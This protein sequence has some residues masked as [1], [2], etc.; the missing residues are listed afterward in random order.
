[1]EAE[2]QQAREIIQPLLDTENGFVKVRCLWIL[3]ILPYLAL[4]AVTKRRLG[5]TG[6]YLDPSVTTM[7][8]EMCRH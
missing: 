3:Q 7:L 8:T 1:M 2:N 4:C 6:K 5:I